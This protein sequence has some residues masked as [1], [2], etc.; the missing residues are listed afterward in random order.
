MTAAAAA[1]V[2]AAASTPAAAGGLSRAPRS[3]LP[4]SDARPV[5]TAAFSREDGPVHQ[6]M[7]Q[8]QTLLGGKTHVHM[9]ESAGHRKGV[10]TKG[11]AGRQVS[12]RPLAQRPQSGIGPRQAG[13]LMICQ[14]GRVEASVITIRSFTRRAFCTSLA[15]RYH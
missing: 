7:R 13:V 5:L 10:R 4:P 3:T 1:S 9:Q 2:G 6:T 11:S 8:H 14:C 12:W 15:C